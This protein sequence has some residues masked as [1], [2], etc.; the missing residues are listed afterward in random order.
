MVIGLLFAGNG[1][2]HCLRITVSRNIANGFNRWLKKNDLFIDTAALCGNL[3]KRDIANG[4]NRWLKTI[5]QQA[6]LCAQ[7]PGQ[8]KSWQHNILVMSPTIEPL[9]GD[10]RW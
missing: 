10:C 4:L 3:R 7:Q 2:N 6:M 5:I 9:A 8:Y 1:L